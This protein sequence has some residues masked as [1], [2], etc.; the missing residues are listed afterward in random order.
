MENLT[1]KPFPGNELPKKPGNK[2]KDKERGRI[3]SLSSIQPKGSKL[4]PKIRKLSPQKIADAG[5]H[6]PIFHGSPQLPQILEE[7]FKIQI[8]TGTKRQMGI[9]ILTGCAHGYQFEEYD[10]GTPPPIHHLGLGVY[11][12]NSKAVAKEFSYKAPGYTNPPRFFLNSKRILQINF[13]SPKRM[14]KWWKDHGYNPPKDILQSRDFNAWLKATKNLTQT[15]RAQ[16]DAVW[17]TNRGLYKLLD[18]AQICVFRPNLIVLE[19]PSKAKPFELGSEI[20]HNQTTPLLE[21]KP[22]ENTPDRELKLKPHPNKEGWREIIWEDRSYTLHQIPPPN[23][24]GKIV[25]ITVPPKGA[26]FPTRYT[27]S[28]KKGPTINNYLKEELQSVPKK[29]VKQEDH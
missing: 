19:D 5:Y 22:P 6:G 14:M 1:W 28:W 17:F 29:K 27:I 2:T 11:L 3:P 24:K 20:T 10:Q 9:H 18:G 8:P 21:K 25:H 16:Y 23:L 15:L 12:T 26:Q 13:G 7:G 4:V